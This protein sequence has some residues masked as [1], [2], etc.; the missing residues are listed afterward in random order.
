MKKVLKKGFTLIELLIVIGI[1]GIIIAAVLLAINPANAQR[2]ARDA[3]RLKDLGTLQTVMDQLVAENTLTADLDVNSGTVTTPACSA[4]GWMGIDV[5]NYA[6]KLPIDPTN[7]STSIAGAAG[8]GACTTTLSAGNA[9]QYIKYQA[10]T[11][12]YEINV[13]QESAS[14]CNQLTSDNGSSNR[15]VE[16]GTATGL[17]LIGDL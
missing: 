6:S 3:Q 16:V 13:R 4:S 15:F 10:S 11:N 8:A 2:K 12:T 5:C 1:L 7:K 9:F 14:N 17:T